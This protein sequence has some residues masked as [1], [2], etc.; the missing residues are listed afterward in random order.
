MRFVLEGG[1]HG[2]ECVVA[3]EEPIMS[4]DGDQPF[5]R[6]EKDG[7]GEVRGNGATKECT[8]DEVELIGNP[9]GGSD[10]DRVRPVAGVEEQEDG[11]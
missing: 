6:G 10:G 3:E 5:D 1:S 4:G 7:E 11:G 8:D 9:D 2:V